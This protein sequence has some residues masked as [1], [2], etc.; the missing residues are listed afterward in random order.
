[1]SD[2]GKF[3][4]DCQQHRSTCLNRRQ[5]VIA[6]GM[7]TATLLLGQVFPGR[8]RAEDAGR[9]VQVARMP[10]QE[11]A[12]LSQLDADR[13]LEF[14]YPRD[15][16]HASAMLVK[17]NRPAGGGIGPDEDVVAFSTICTHM[18]GDLSYNAQHKIAGP[19]EIHLTS[20]DLT[21]HGMVV[22]GHATIPLPQI[23]LELEGETIFATGVVG[24]LYGYH[25]NPTG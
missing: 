14:D 4:D 20:F 9:E 1:M 19:C 22:A 17:L 2:S 18:G 25:A 6:G 13:A 11:V 12:R 23:I 21:R 8:V 7:G 3:P 5:F 10:R 24:L 16:P 15:A